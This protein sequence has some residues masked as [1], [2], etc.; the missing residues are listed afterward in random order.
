MHALCCRV[1]PW[2]FGP[3][4]HLLVHF[5][6]FNRPG[7]IRMYIGRYIQANAYIVSSLQKKPTTTRALEACL[8][9]FHTASST[10]NGFKSTYPSTSKPPPRASNK[11][12]RKGGVDEGMLS[13]FNRNTENANQRTRSTVLAFE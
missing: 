6:D 5:E 8:A 1:P 13:D 12:C 11:S 9:R 2:T 7:A 10:Q 4:L 3:N